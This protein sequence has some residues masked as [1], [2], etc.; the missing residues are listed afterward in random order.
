MKGNLAVSTQVSVRLLVTAGLLLVC[1][2]GGC[3]SERPLQPSKALI[4]KW[5]GVSYDGEHYVD[6]YFKAGPGDK[7]TRTAVSKKDGE[8]ANAEYVVVG[9]KIPLKTAQL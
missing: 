4:G 9:E 5:K 8:V 6:W 3:S 2:A 7:L 1:I